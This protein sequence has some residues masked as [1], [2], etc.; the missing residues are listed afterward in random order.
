MKLSPEQQFSILVLTEARNIFRN[1]ELRYIGISRMEKLVAYVADIIDYQEL[2]R[3]WYKYGLFAPE[4]WI[5]ARKYSNNNDLGSFFV[6]YRLY[7][8]SRKELKHLVSEIKRAISQLRKHFITETENFYRW[9]YQRTPPTF[10]QFYRFKLEFENSLRSFK[11]HYISYRHLLE[12]DFTMVISSIDGL[13]KNVAHVDDQTIDIFHNYMD[14]VELIFIKLKNE[15]F[16]IP[17]DKAEFFELY[18][19]IL[20]TFS[21]KDEYYQSDL[22]SLLAPFEQTVVGSNANKWIEVIQRKAKEGKIILPE[23]IEGL[24]NYAESL[25]LLPTISELEQELDILN[26]K[27]KS[28]REILEGI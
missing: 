2:T 18:D 16:K 5:I 1:Y 28:L 14:L 19:K 11:V 4:A 23:Q 22:L 9:I 21:S 7:S 10:R 26:G 13:Y 17:C 15:K 6:P 20:Y 8:K 24:Y 3:G 25:G 27:R 12:E